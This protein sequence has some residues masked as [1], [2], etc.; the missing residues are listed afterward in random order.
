MKNIFFVFILFTVVSSCSFSKLKEEKINYNI[1]N[2]QE[3]ENDSISAILLNVTDPV[4][5]KNGFEMDKLGVKIFVDEGKYYVKYFV[6]VQNYK[7]GGAL[8]VFDKKMK[9]IEKY[10][11]E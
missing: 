5:K 2:L 9:I 7:G 1:E 10:F 3:L 4:M 11:Q 8:I 6:A